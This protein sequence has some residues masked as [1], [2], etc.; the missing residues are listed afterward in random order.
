ML[1]VKRSMNIKGCHYQKNSRNSFNV[2]Y[3]NIKTISRTLV[4]N[5]MKL[6]LIL[7]YLIYLLI[8]SLFVVKYTSRQDYYN[9]YLLTIIYFV[10]MLLLPYLYSIFSLKDLF[11][12]YTF[13]LIVFIFF[14]FTI[15]LN[16][17]ID[18][19]T[20]NVDRWSAMEVGIEALLN[21]NY[22]YSA[23]DHLGGRT[24][25]LPTLIFV[26]IPFY[27]VIL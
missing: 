21:G 26:G 27:N 23:T 6:T 14:A 1:E 22:P 5:N 19:K 12:K 25:N 8:N 9:E 18:G 17:M 13:F 24:S 2:D 16:I 3:I 20:L 7:P 4:G 11:Y 15:Y 10:L